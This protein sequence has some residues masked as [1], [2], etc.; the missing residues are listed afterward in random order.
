MYSQIEVYVFL[1]I[2]DKVYFVIIEF[3]STKG[4]GIDTRI[5]EFILRN[6]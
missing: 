3:Y 5:I 2:F 1:Y 4:T 6:N